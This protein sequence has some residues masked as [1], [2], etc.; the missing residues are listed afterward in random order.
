MRSG[1]NPL[2]IGLVQFTRGL[3]FTRQR[4]QGRRVRGG[5]IRGV[6]SA[7]APSESADWKVFPYSAGLLQAF[8]A[9]HAE[10]R[11]RLRFLP[12]AHGWSTVESTVNAL[13]SADVAAFSAYVWNIE[14]SLAVA[15]ALKARR[16]ETLVIFGG[17]QVP[18][19]AEEFLR[20]HPYIDLVCHGEGER[21]FAAVIDRAADGDW[22]GIAGVSYLEGGQFVHHAPGA[23][24]H[25][26][27][28]VP[29]PYLEGVF[30]PLLDA[31]PS[32]RWV[33]LW[34]TNR[35]CPFACTFCDWGSAIA[36]KV[37]QFDR[38]RLV[39]ELE[40]FAARKGEYI[41]CCDANFGLLPRDVELAREAAAIKA[42][43]G[44]PRTLS[45]QNTKNATE[46]AYQI[47]KTLADAVM[48]GGVTLS[49]QSTDLHTL[50]MVKRDNISLESFR[51]LQRRYARDGIPTYTDMIL[52]LPGET[53]DSF[54]NG[55]SNTIASGQHARIY[56]Y[57]SALLPNAEMSQP[58][59]RAR[60]GLQ[61]VRQAILDLHGRL[62][63]SEGPPEF[64][65]IVVGTNSMPADDWVRAK[66]FAWL[67]DLLHFNRLLVVP[68][69]LLHRERGIAFRQLV[70]TIADADPARY[71]VMAGVRHALDEHA[72]AIRRGGPEFIASPEWLGTH[73]PAD[74]H[75]LITL[76]TSW[77]TDAFYEEAASL[78][79]SLARD[80]PVTEAVELNR[81][82]LRLPF[83]LEDGELT[84][85]WNL[86]EYVTA[87]LGGSPVPL[88]RRP[89]QYRIERTRPI[90]LGWDDWLEHVIFCH[91]QKATYLYP[92]K[93]IDVHTPDL[94]PVGAA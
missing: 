72:R 53:Y 26:L 41:F 24:M 56:F 46:R 82:L 14:R 21:V 42:R 25:A 52:G 89:T 92:L 6:V 91:N 58:E 68:F 35:G 27:D 59:S 31:D 23:R 57:N 87:A 78:L 60:F 18:D 61:T 3:T 85:E 36:S 37:Y 30:N 86:W 63:G 84:L 22:S 34:E 93:P 64:L 15:R 49:L 8:V 94:S 7:S 40:W 20:A 9:R 73:W 39:A 54:A 50:E 5:S 48:N 55:I 17:P 47:Q 19:K 11:D 66:T 51:E 29:S 65:E 76:A 4:F 71:P 43:H 67:T 69:V 1:H 28:I 10:S 16:P 38:D 2:V 12:I 90:W 79:G 32:Q 44:Y 33:M 88:E 75:A 45:V 62:D 83:E 81:Q 77:Q 80:L 74:Q 70:E 13:A